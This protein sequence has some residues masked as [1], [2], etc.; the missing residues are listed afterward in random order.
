MFTDVV[1]VHGSSVATPT[2]D[3]IEP[4]LFQGNRHEIL[5]TIKK[6]WERREGDT[7]KKVL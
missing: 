5:A 3:S 2:D 6:R 4:L 1:G 7:T